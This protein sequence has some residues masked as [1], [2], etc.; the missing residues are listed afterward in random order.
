ML[1]KPPAVRPGDPVAIIAPAGP[2][3]RASFDAGHAVLEQRYRVR[4]DTRLFERFRYLAGDDSRRLEEVRSALED[5][6]IKAI[7]CARGG[8]GTM[9]LIPRLTPLVA[10]KPVVGF[11]D[12]TALHLCVQQQEAVSIHGPVVTQLGRQPEATRQRLFAL[13]ES[14]SAAPP[15]YG[16]D[17][18]V[19]GKVEGPLIG[20]N[21]AV[22]SRL[23]G[24]PY[25]PSLEEAV[26]LLEDVGE[27][28]YRLDRMW[29]H[30]GLAGVFR[31]VSGIVLGSFAA[32]EERDADYT[33]AAVLRTLAEETGLP[34]AAGF[35][36]GHGDINEAVPLGA[37]VRLDADARRLEFLEAA[38]R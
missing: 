26:L 38:V 16:T 4:H 11:S 9:R 19:G 25:L 17:T 28:P 30:L 1:R 12:I 37:R 27:R 13:L 31:K 24:T 21:L 14:T 8:Y 3:D 7:F 22:L 33:S 35:P 18:Y 32:C 6:G 10:T 5:P 34:C 23:L 36:I 29:T 15:L 20:G 2:F